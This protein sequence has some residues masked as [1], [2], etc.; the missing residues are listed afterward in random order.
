[1]GHSGLDLL[2]MSFSH[3]DPQPT[4]RLTSRRNQSVAGIE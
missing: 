2:T 3:L 4:C 1:M